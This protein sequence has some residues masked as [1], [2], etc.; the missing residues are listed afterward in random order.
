MYTPISN[1][2]AIFK[3]K[4]GKWRNIMSLES[5]RYRSRTN[6]RI[7][8]KKKSDITKG[9]PRWQRLRLRLRCLWRRSSLADQNCS[10][11]A[12][13]SPTEVKSSNR[14]W[15]LDFRILIRKSPF[16]DSVT[17]STFEF[18]FQLAFCKEICVQATL[19]RME[20]KITMLLGKNHV[21]CTILID[22]IVNNIPSDM[23][24]L[25]SSKNYHVFQLIIF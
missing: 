20:P 23:L 3:N 22:N 24:S 14:R 8:I 2:S 15:V 5:M 16:R 12:V 25:D 4:K 1:I 18:T 11:G 9:Q 10:S 6:E 19:P 17:E 13:L 7:E 21:W